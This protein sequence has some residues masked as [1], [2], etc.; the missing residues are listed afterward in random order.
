MTI[1]TTA[2]IDDTNL[3]SQPYINLFN[4]L[5]NQDNIPDP[6]GKTNRKMV[7]TRF[8]DVDGGSE[9][10]KGY[11]FIVV[12]PIGS[13]ESNEFSLDRTR[14]NV[15]WEVEVE[16][17]SSDRIQNLQGNGRNY[18]DQ[19]SNNLIKTINSL[20]NKK[21]L[22][23]LGMSNLNANVLSMDI[24]SLGGETTYR[25]RFMVEFSRRLIIS[26]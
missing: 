10:F 9:S 12:N 4:L 18:L 14:A 23:A 3:F 17:Y 8:P 22:S 25:R 24:I 2:A 6:S 26:A 19:I 20:S 13:E 5:D 15:G 7:Y 21:T 11:P 1:G 16:V